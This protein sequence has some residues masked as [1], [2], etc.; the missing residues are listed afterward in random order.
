MAKNSP[1]EKM[2]RAAEETQPTLSQG[3]LDRPAALVGDGDG[4]SVLSDQ[5]G[6]PVS[7]TLPNPDEDIADA[8]TIGDFSEDHFW[9]SG[10]YGRCFLNFWRGAPANKKMVAANI[11]WGRPK[12]RRGD[13]QKYQKLGVK[14]I[15]W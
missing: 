2:E 4:I 10:I 14:N 15:Y 1:A 13:D 7:E 8:S 12:I 5:V 3:G 9:A 11:F 6:S